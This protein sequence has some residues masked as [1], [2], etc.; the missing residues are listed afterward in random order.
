MVQNYWGID[1]VISRCL[2][3]DREQHPGD[4]DA[5][6]ALLHA[7]ALLQARAEALREQ[8]GALEAVAS[9]ESRA[10]AAAGSGACHRG[11]GPVR[12]TCGS[13]TTLLLRLLVG[14]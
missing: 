10:A 3:A 9:A 1:E 8:A 11:R 2:G 4:L 13:G 7:A 12:G 6:A 5:E 14:W